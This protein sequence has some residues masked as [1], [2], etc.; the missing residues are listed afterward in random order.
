[1]NAVPSCH[2][3]KGQLDEFKNFSDLYQVTSD[4]RPWRK[5]GHLCICQ[6]CGIVQKPVTRQWKRDT[7]DI[8]NGYEIINRQADWNKGFLINQV[9]QMK[10]VQEK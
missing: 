2:I 8:Y 7:E 5:D 1:M 4:C 3:C 10:C 9:E 6:K